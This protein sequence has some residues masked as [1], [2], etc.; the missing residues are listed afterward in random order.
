MYHES[1]KYWGCLYAIEKK[2]HHYHSFR[3]W[4]EGKSEKWKLGCDSN[5]KEC[6]AAPHIYARGAFSYF[7]IIVSYSKTLLTADLTRQV[8]SV[9][10]E[11]T[12]AKLAHK[13]CVRV[14]IVRCGRL[15]P[16]GFYWCIRKL[17][18]V[19]AYSKKNSLFIF[20]GNRRSR[21]YTMWP[22]ASIGVSQSF[23]SKLA[24]SKDSLR[25]FFAIDLEPRNFLWHLCVSPFVAHSPVWFSVFTSHTDW[26]ISIPYSVTLFSRNISL[27]RISL[28]VFERRREPQMCANSQRLQVAKSEDSRGA[29][30]ETS[31]SKKC[32]KVSRTKLQGLSSPRVKRRR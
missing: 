10:G 18:P 22:I 11:M 26:R 3:I 2:K 19:D 14:A 20:A 13:G 28:L 16:L 31:S 12:A 17:L 9:C 30:R 8:D 15:S 1:G 29:G 6:V 4:K 24:S 7:N 25:I 23:S 32:T 21:S 5:N 27:R